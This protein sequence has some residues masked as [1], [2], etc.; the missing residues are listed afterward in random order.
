METVCYV[1][2]RWIVFFWWNIVRTIFPNLNPISKKSWWQDSSTLRDI[3]GLRWTFLYWLPQSP[4]PSCRCGGINPN[5]QRKKISFVP[6]PHKDYKIGELQ[7]KF[8]LHQKPSKLSSR[9]N[10]GFQTGRSMDN[11]FCLIEIVVKRLET[12]ISV[13]FIKVYNN[14][15]YLYNNNKSH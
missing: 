12:H 1:F 8:P 11:I 10:F 4:F 7:E 6:E 15:F 9:G 14:V 13:D 5:T 3:P 2:C